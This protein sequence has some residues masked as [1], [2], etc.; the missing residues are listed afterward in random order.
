MQAEF[1]FHPQAINIDSF[2]LTEG[3]IVLVHISQN[4]PMGGNIW[5]HQ[6]GYQL[7]RL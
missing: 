5:A 7:C 1:I 2:H 6:L 4:A 3:L